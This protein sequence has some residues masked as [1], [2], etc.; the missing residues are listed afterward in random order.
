MKRLAA[1]VL[2]AALAFP[3]CQ[4]PAQPPAKSS[5]SGASPAAS[6]KASSAPAKLK[7]AAIITGVV[8]APR[9]IIGGVLPTGGSNVI[10]TGGS[11]VLPT[12][13]SNVLPT[14]GS[15][16]RT[17]PGDGLRR[18]LAVAEAPLANASVYVA[19]A[20]GNAYPRIEAV[21]TD[22]EGRFTLPDV[23]AG[24]TVTVV[25]RGHDEGRDKD[26]TLQTIVKTSELGATT[27]IDTAT[28]L[29]TLAV[30]Q[31]SSE[32]GDINAASFRTATEATARSLTDADVPDLSDR[33]AILA[34]VEALA[35]TVAELKQALD[36][37]REDIQDI[38]ASLEDITQKLGAPQQ[39]GGW[40]PPPPPPAR[41]GQ[42]QP[43]GFPPP[44]GPGGLPPGGG[45][46]HP[47]VTHDL[48]LKGTYTGYPLT[49]Q[50]LA[51]SGDVI[52]VA[53]F[54]AAGAPA[55][56][57]VP[58]VCPHHL[59]LLDGTGKQLAWHPDFVFQQGTPRAVQLPI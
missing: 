59:R 9:G 26:V 23:P 1:T 51:R 53:T 45:C 46:P 44:Q 25:V 15:N 13:G 58:D 16:L 57:D 6:P 43:G 29:V 5:N 27:K 33:S 11:N 56:L 18:L 4:Q 21:T 40:Q 47:R 36:E 42:P 34:K 20:A 49:L 19:D 55:T 50:L 35:E 41:P 8:R 54:A 22:A 3:A 7:S 17:S 2:L 37:I 28:S 10:P 14:G 52:A 48:T 38:K 32:I 24:F 30:L 39:T 12:G 31:G